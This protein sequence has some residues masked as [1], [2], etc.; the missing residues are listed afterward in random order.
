[1]NGGERVRMVVGVPG[2]IRTP[3]LPLRRGLLYPA[4]LPELHDL[5]S[6]SGYHH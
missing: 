1:M 3:D 4:E 5:V 6:G 2:G